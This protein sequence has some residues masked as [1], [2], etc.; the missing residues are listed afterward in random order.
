VRVKAAFSH[1]LDAIHRGFSPGCGNGGNRGTEDNDEWAFSFSPDLHRRDLEKPHQE[2]DARV[3]SLRQDSHISSNTTGVTVFFFL[4]KHIYYPPSRWAA[5]P[6]IDYVSGEEV[7]PGFPAGRCYFAAFPF[8]SRP[9]T[10]NR[11]VGLPSD[12][13]FGNLSRFSTHGQRAG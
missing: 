1:N 5:C 8:A 13:E 6:E 11:E 3:E 10:Q 7:R 9:K 4:Y 12:Q 2:Q